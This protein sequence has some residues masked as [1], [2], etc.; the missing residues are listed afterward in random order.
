VLM[1]AISLM[2]CGLPGKYSGFLDGLKIKV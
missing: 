1:H 2:G